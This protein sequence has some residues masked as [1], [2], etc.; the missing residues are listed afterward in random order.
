M[1]F[2]HAA[3]RRLVYAQQLGE[4]A[5]H[6]PSLL[7]MVRLAC[8]HTCKGRVEWACSCICARQH[9]DSKLSALLKRLP[10]ILVTPLQR[11]TSCAKDMKPWQH[12]F[13]RDE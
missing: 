2:R 3:T 11:Y 4:L 1:L 12:C 13:V 5:K 10:Q 9:H 7:G 8:A 6:V